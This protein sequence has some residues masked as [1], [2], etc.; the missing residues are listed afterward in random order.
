MAMFLL[1]IAY[2]SEETTDAYQFNYVFYEENNECFI[3]FF[4][5]LYFE[6]ICF[7]LKKNYK[8]R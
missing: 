2:Q 5:Q 3:V 7:F 4:M 8:L 1:F 6:Y